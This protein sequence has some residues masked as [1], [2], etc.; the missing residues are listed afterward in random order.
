LLFLNS[1]LDCFARQ[2]RADRALEM[3][4]ESIAV[5]RPADAVSLTLLLSACAR[6]RTT[7]GPLLAQVLQQAS[8]IVKERRIGRADAALRFAIRITYERRIANLASLQPSRR[9]RRAKAA[10]QAADSALELWRSLAR[11]LALDADEIVRE[12]EAVRAGAGSDPR[13]SARW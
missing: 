8:A 6:D 4:R 5:G 2:R 11:S 10:E 1:L 9:G 3:L 13:H 7:S 12:V